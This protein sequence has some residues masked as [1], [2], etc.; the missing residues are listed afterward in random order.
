M[1]RA[2][3]FAS[4]DQTAKH[5]S[6]LTLPLICRVG[7]TGGGT[8]VCCSHV[9]TGTLIHSYILRVSKV[10][11]GACTRRQ[12]ATNAS[13]RG[14]LAGGICISSNGSCFTNLCSSANVHFMHWSLWLDGMHEPLRHTLSS[15]APAEFVI[16]HWRGSSEPSKTRRFAETSQY[17]LFVTLSVG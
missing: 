9:G 5:S 6:G 11:K 3:D 15:E 16:C 1:E 10:L 4:V 12:R 8:L 7:R 13:F 2:V 17:L 14:R